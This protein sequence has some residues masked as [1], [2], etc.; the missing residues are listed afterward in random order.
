M[1]TVVRMSSRQW[2]P[3]RGE[4][5]KKHRG[6]HMATAKNYIRGLFYPGLDLHLRNRASLC[7]YWMAG[8][9]DVLDAG[10]GN[11]YFAW[12]AYRSGARVCALSYDGAQ[13]AKAREFLNG[14]GKADPRRLRFEQ[15]NLYELAAVDGPFDEIICYEVLEHIRRDA[16]VVKEFHR[17][18]RPGGVLHLCCPNRLHPR[19]RSEVLDLAES[20]GHVRPGYTEEDYRQLLEPLGFEIDLVVGIG[21]RSVYLADAVLR[22]IRNR[23]GD[24][25]A[26]PLFPLMLP[27]VWLARSNPKLPFSI[28]ARAI[29][30]AERPWAVE[31][32]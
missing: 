9:R 7:R 27:F 16:E 13:V 19:H 11:G 24:A 23:V 21:P 1:R 26:L 22:F 18:L 4:Q 20:G 14:H 15:R 8:S 29:K 12:R 2:P 6:E 3:R 5:G 17:M 10:S 28:Y 31:S 32:L 30:R 25:W